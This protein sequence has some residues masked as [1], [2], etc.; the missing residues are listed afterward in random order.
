MCVRQ[1]A[2]K[3]KSV[4]EKQ[5]TTE[6][7]E[8]REGDVYRFRYSEAE[9]TRWRTDPYWCFDGQLVVQNGVL[10]DTYWGFDGF[11]DRRVVKPHEGELIFVC[12]LNDVRDIKEYE[13]RHFDESDIF[14]LTHHAGHRKRFVVKKDA[15]VSSERMLDEVRK[16]ER[17]VRE[18]M[19]LAC[20]SAAS[21]LVRLGELRARIEAGD[22]SRKPWW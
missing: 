18:E 2:R 6:S 11:S 17:A 13:V 15:A 3:D 20:R 7:V 21:D 4:S 5:G 9:R 10:V 14:N 12:N 16:K 22:L 8:L 1:T 19:E